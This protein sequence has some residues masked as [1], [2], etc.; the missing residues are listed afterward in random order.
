MTDKKPTIYDL[1][2]SLG[3]SVGTVYRALHNTGRISKE[4]KAR[5][6][7]KAE[8]M[9]FSPNRSAQGLSRT[10]I[11]VGAILCCP[12]IPFLDEIRSGI[13]H[14]FSSLSQYNVFSDIRIM[15]PQ[16]AEDC[17]E[18]IS[19]CLLE[20][21][22]R[23]YSGIILF[24]SG[25]HEKC[26][27]A[28]RA[29]EKAKIPMVC[30]TN[31]IPYKNRVAYIC[32]DG[33]CAGCISAELLSMTCQNQHIAI[34]TGSIQV[35]RQSIQGFT[36]ES[37][38]FKSTD[39][40]EHHDQPERVAQ[41]LLEIFRHK[42]AY[43][44]IYINS[45]SSIIACPMLMELNQDREMKI[46]A[47]DLFPQI[48]EPLDVGI[49]NATIFQNPFLQGKKAVSSIYRHLHGE[50]INPVLKISPQIILRSNIDQY[51]INCTNHIS[52]TD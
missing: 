15:P 23:K 49:I 20:F 9:N 7:E 21:I 33:Y 17:G 22:E 8:E 50:A 36:E 35:H 6:L 44:G 4:T 26:D 48:K 25:S 37:R 16:N 28:L 2:A 31:D 51:H 32:C 11:T 45:A 38:G 13:D 47:T 34:L 39:I 46:I 18:Q 27:D 43:Q 29:V 40:Y 24:L 52:L 3:I 30:I 14:E 41:Q 5:V 12:V 10:P 1:A 42:P 19:R